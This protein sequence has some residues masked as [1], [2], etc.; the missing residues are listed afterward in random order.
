MN[1][2]ESNLEEKLHEINHHHVDEATKLVNA[3]DKDRYPDSQAF[4][5]QQV[6]SMDQTL[7]ICMHLSHKTGVPRRR[8]L[9][10]GDARAALRL[11]HSE[12][13]TEKILV[14]IIQAEELATKI[15]IANKE[16]AA[17]KL[18]L[19]MRAAV[20]PA[21]D[22]GVPDGTAMQ[23]QDLNEVPAAHPQQGHQAGG[24]VGG[25]VNP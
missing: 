17:E 2:V 10:F 23:S 1:P 8:A 16:R 22:D 15:F 3:R 7:H 13:Y 18:S 4:G 19:S 6:E 12:E 14:C 9:D 21:G 24:T 11:V 20:T 5:V 25:T